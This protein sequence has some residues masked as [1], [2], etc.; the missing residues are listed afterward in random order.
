VGQLVATRREGWRGSGGCRR[1]G[2]CLVG[3][4]HDPGAAASSRARERQGKRENGE[5]RGGWRVG[6]TRG[7]AQLTETREWVTYGAGYSANCLN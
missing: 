1:R 2:T 3:D 5:S 6:P 4:V 7:G